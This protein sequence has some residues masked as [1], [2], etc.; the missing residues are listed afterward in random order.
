VDADTFLFGS[1]DEVRRYTLGTGASEPLVTLMRN[2]VEDFIWDARQQYL[3][4]ISY[5]CTIALCDFLTGEKLDL[6]RDQMDYSKGLA[7]L[8]ASV[9]RR[10]YPWDFITWGR[11][12]TA[13]RFRIH[14]ERIVALGPLPVP[15]P[16]SAPPAP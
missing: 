13:H 14:D 12:G 9:D 4:A 7:W 8:D 15:S 1:G 6:V 11:S 10:L 5:Q 3:L 16:P 2:T